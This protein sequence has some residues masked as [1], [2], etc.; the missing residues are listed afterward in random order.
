MRTDRYAILLICI[1]AIAW[2]QLLAQAPSLVVE[3]QGNYLHVSCAA[4]A[5]SRRQG[6][7]SSCTTALR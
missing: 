6:L 2:F 4:H 7:W 5:L 1:S 3:R